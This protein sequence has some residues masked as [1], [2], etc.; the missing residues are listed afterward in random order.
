[1]R[2]LS[3]KR[4]LVIFFVALP[5]IPVLVFAFYFTNEM[6]KE[7]VNAFV[8][9]TNNE[10]TQVDQ[11]FT[12]FVDGLK[13]MTQLLATTP[14]FRDVG[15]TLPNYI[16]GDD[17][18][19]LFNNFQQ[20]AR[21]SL[22]VL[23]QANK[24]ISVSS[25]VYLGTQQC[26]FLTSGLDSMPPRTM[27]L[28]PRKRG[29]YKA[30]VLKG[31]VIVTPSYQSGSGDIVVTV[32][33][34]CFF[35]DNQLVGVVGMD[36]SLSTLTDVVRNISIGSTGYVILAQDDGMILAN[37][38]QKKNDFKTIDSL[39]VAEFANLAQME[40]SFKEITLDGQTYLATVHSSPS[41]GY[42]F[43]GLITKNEILGKI[44]AI[45]KIV[46]A[47]VLG[48]IL[49]FTV[50][51][52]WLSNSIV[53]PLDRVA[54]LIQHIEEQ[55]DL[56]KRLTIEKEDEIGSLAHLFNVFI[57]KLHQVVQELKK[58]SGA[59]HQSA[60]QLNDVSGQL[61]SES[62]ST[63]QR[64]ATV[65]TAAEAAS[66]NLADV[67]NAMEQSSANTNIIAA[68]A[69]EMRAT[70]GGIAERSGQAK[71]ISS[72]A[73]KGTREAACFMEA[74]DDAANKIGKATE[75]ITEISEQTNLLALNATIEA[76]RAGTAGKGFAVVANEIKALAQHTAEA[77]LNISHLVEAV[78]K[79]TQR[80][81]ESI[82]TIEAVIHE[83]NEII[84]AITQAVAEHSNATDEIV[85]TITQVSL[86]IQE[87][88]E[89]VAQSSQAVSNITKEIR[90]ISIAATRITKDSK[91][92]AGNAK[93][94]SENSEKLQE[95]V[96]HFHV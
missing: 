56:T 41:L 31:D 84:T 58:N 89:N 14:A 79:T 66:S 32:A 85:T 50:L 15:E 92:L 13:K 30:A 34:P 95:I 10:L 36:V 52:L 37:P 39:G 3:V 74:L 19:V 80:T 22:D 17:P 82:T 21:R 44:V 64:S 73:V 88:N 48:F 6:K 78:Q 71:K 9:S 70:M 29:W 53:N 94:L 63:E 72:R 12:F 4:K 54:S 86:G 62:A 33:A 45:Q 18:A 67:A 91:G 51:A 43:I 93:G 40:N 16:R 8:S 28:D 27:K 11:G 1:M 77:T 23:I 7:A 60:S 38:R 20:P 61:L 83:V 26:G 24:T 42:R 25:I 46:L 87:V 76:A 65:T 59:L 5:L 68:A 2:V 57:E 90:G 35:A 69:E 49:F 75:T 47:L 96:R 55:G 81:G